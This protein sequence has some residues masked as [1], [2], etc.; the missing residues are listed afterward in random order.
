MLSTLLCL[1]HRR[2][3]QRKAAVAL[4]PRINLNSD[5]CAAN[6]NK[7]SFMYC[8]LIES[9]ISAKACPLTFCG[10]ETYPSRVDCCVVG[11]VADGVAVSS[12]RHMIIQVNVDVSVLKSSLPQGI[13][14]SAIVMADSTSSLLANFRKKVL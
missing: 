8:I 5:A 14:N 4:I 11:A 1:C 10:G 7:C 13:S 9:I 6:V 2:C 12:K 3:G